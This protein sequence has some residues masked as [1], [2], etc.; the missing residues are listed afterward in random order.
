MTT[1]S[2]FSPSLPL[3]ALPSL[4][5]LVRLPHTPHAPCL[6]PDTPAPTLLFTFTLLIPSASAAVFAAPLWLHV[7]LVAILCRVPYAGSDSTESDSFP[8]PP[9]E[10]AGGMASSPM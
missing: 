8:D 3:L 9:C 1:I 7:V 4:S 2:V 10:R 5:H 6:C